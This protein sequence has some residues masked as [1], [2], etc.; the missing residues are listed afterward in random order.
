GD[1]MM[2]G[3]IDTLLQSHGYDYPFRKL[4]SVLKDADVAL[5]N[6]ENP[7]TDRGEPADKSYVFRT[8]PEAVP[9]IQASG[10]DV[11]NLANN[12]TLDYGLEGLRDTIRYLDEAGIGWI[13]A[14]ENE[15]EAYAPYL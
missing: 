7:I 3:R 11:L 10:L 2:G 14:G 12:H 5:G 4:G 1:I 9:A 8:S 13:G 6:L 15:E